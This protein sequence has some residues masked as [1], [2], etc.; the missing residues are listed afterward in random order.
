MSVNEY[1]KKRQGRMPVDDPRTHCVSVRLNDEELL[2]L[3]QQRGKMMKGE[4]LRCAAFDKLPVQIPE[5]NRNMW[6]ELSRS[7]ANLNKIARSLIEI[8]NKNINISEYE[9][10]LI[11]SELQNFRNNL[12]G[13]KP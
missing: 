5:A 1:R 3:N 6:I 2:L 13:K 8:N 9:I 10:D 11:K 4:Y 7:A 12:V